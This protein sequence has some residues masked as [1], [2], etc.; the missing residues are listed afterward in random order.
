MTYDLLSLSWELCEIISHLPLFFV[1][2]IM[3]SNAIGVQLILQMELD[4]HEGITATAATVNPGGGGRGY[5]PASSLSDF[6]LC[7]HTLRGRCGFVSPACAA[8]Q[9]TLSH[10]LHPWTGMQM[11]VPSAETDF[12][13]D[14]SR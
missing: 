5:G 4:L 11:V 1:V 6:T 3:K 12:V 10:L 9:D 2:V 7:M 14:F 13:G 8:K